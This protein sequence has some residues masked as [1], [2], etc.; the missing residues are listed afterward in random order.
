V[1]IREFTLQ[2]YDAVVELW[3]S[4]GGGVTLR[5]SDGRAEI[6]KKLT[7]DPDLFLVTEVDASV[8]GVIM[9]AWDGRRGWLYHLTVHPNYRHLGIASS[10]MEEAERRLRAKGCLK[11][12]LMVHRD[13]AIARQLYEHRG[14]LESTPFVVMGKEL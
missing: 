3:R 8:V 7:R 12:N 10:L 11:V 13:N 2:D 6:E 14:Y 1:H 9:G 5:P 4:A